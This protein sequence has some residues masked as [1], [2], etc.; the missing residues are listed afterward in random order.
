M[1]RLMGD[2]SDAIDYR[3]WTLENLEKNMVEVIRYQD[4]WSNEFMIFING[5]MMLPVG[6]P[7]T[8][9]SPSGEY[10]LAKGSSHP[11]SWFFAYSKSL[12]SKSK[13]DQAVLDELLERSHRR[14]T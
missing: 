1:N 14:H 2:D 8:A 9:V 4:K 12:G 7:L 13:V 11:I 10:F 6:F 3:K 5:V